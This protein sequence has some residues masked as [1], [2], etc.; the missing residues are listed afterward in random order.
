MTINKWLFIHIPKTGGTWFK[1]SLDVFVPPEDEGEIDYLYLT[2]NLGGNV[3]S[4][5]AASVEPLGARVENLAH[6]FPYEFT[7][8]GWN[9]K[10]DKYFHM[11]FLKDMQYHLKFNPDYTEQDDEI[12]YVSIVRNPFDLFYS[13]WRYR[14]RHMDDWVASTDNHGG[15]FGC[16]AIMGTETFND[17][18]E[19]YLDDE[20]EWHIPPL[21]ENLFAQ[22]Y[23]KDGTLIPKME[24]VLRT[25]R[26]QTDFTCWCDKNNIPYRTTVPKESNAN[27]IKDTYKDKYTRIQIAQLTCK[28]EPILAKFGYHF[29][30]PN[31][32]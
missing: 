29:G 9:P 14:P 18:V 20:K 17:F 1:N 23:R 28:W 25:E 21:K 10:S 4:A 8:N 12:G 6:S 3:A 24:N 27:P 2:D 15:W 13:Y 22:L 5:A 30:G 19:R 31:E 11:P 16:N 32:F 26:L 7:V